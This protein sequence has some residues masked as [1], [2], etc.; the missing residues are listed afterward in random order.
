MGHPVTGRD[1]RRMSALA[2]ALAALLGG[3]P[4]CGSDSVAGVLSIPHGQAAGAREPSG[5]P[6][7]LPG[8]TCF[9]RNAY[10]EFRAGDLPIVISAPHGGALEPEEIPNRQAGTTVTDLAT[11]DLAAAVAAAL[12][13]RTGREPSLVVCRL[14][15]SKLDV[16][17]DIAEGAQGNPAAERAW[18]EY[19]GFLDA[20]RALA[21][22]LN[23][24]ALVIDLH[25]HGHP[26]P[27]VE[28]GYLLSAA[29]LDRSDAV[30]DDAEWA[31]RS[32][33]RALAAESG[34]RFSAL[35][36]GPASLGGLL[37]SAGY[38]SV[39]GPVTPSPGEDPYFEGGYI[40]RRYG[41]ADGGRTGAVQI[42]TPHAG[43]RDTPA[44]RARFAE[45]LADALLTYLSASRSGPPRSR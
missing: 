22:D 34:L 3:A 42:E 14:K 36:R 27:R 30:L 44:A 16:N 28:I 19:H 24:R 23:G 40:T 32:S 17:R 45:S 41:S 2:F 39:P 21:A 43:V 8:H 20:A 9:G 4:G 38:A 7:C 5:V 25:G 31:R 10:V 12:Q 26:K 13:T 15:R 11:A 33:I 37:Q 6:A 29:D 35:L 1:A 18:N